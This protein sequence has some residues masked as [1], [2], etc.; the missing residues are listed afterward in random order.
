MYADAR[1]RFPELYA[2]QYEQ[3]EML[4]LKFKLGDDPRV[5]PQGRWLRKSSLDE[6]PNFWNVL[7]GEMALVGP[8]PERPE[9]VARLAESR[10]YDH[11]FNELPPETLHAEREQKTEKVLDRKDRAETAAWTTVAGVL[12]NLDE[13]ITRE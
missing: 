9:F 3:N 1:E 13:F 2:Y 8:R 7:T 12:L 10:G 11:V 6:L 5:T 4:S